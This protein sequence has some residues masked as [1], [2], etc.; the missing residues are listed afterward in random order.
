MLIRLLLIAILVVVSLFCWLSLENPLDIEFR[1]FGETL[2]TSVTALMISSFVLGAILVFASTLARDVKRAFESYRQSRQ[3]RKAQSIQEVFNRGMDCYLRGDLGKAKLHFSEVL[4]RDPTQ[5]DLYLRLS[6]I[7][8]KEG[9]G[10]EAIY[11]LERARWIEKR[12]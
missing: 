5:I 8:A 11:W 9:R 10:E 12:S 6:E 4:R 1:F 2:R 7:D 3:K